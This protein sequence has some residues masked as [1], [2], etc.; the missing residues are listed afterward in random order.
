MSGRVQGREREGVRRETRVVVDRNEV[1][2]VDE[3]TIAGDAGRQRISC[4]ENVQILRT[5]SL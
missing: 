5:S 2:K 1:E 3:A 4:A